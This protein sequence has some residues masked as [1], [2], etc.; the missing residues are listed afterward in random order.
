MTSRR[1]T[2]GIAAPPN[3]SAHGSWQGPCTRQP[4][5]AL[6]FALG[7][8]A[9]VVPIARAQTAPAASGANSEKPAEPPKSESNSAPASTEDT[10][11]SKPA[12]SA[13]TETKSESSGAE[14][15]AVAANEGEV[16]GKIPMAEPPAGEQKP[17]TA[18]RQPTMAGQVPSKDELDEPGYLPGYRRYIGLGQSPYTPPVAA[19]PGGFTPGYG[20]PMPTKAWTFTFAG[21]ANISAQ[22]SG[23][24]RRNPT[25]DQSGFV[26][27]TPPRT[28]EEWSSFT[29]SS[30]VPG[31]WVSLRFIYGTSKVSANV[32]IDT[33]N[34]SEPTSYYQMGSQSYINNAYLSFTPEPFGK[35]RLHTNAGQMVSSYGLLGKY[36]GGVYVNPLA[37]TLRGIGETTTVEYDL[38][39]KITLSAEHGF[40]TTRDATPPINN[41]PEVS[42]GYRRLYWAGAYINHAHLGLKLNG[43]YE[44]TAELHYVNAFSHEDRDQALADN[45]QTP[46]I[47]ESYVKDPH[48]HVYTADVKISHDVWGLLGVGVSY[49]HAKHSYRLKGLLTYGGDGEWLTDRWFGVDDRRLGKV[50][51][52]SDQLWVQSRKNHGL[53]N[54][55]FRQWAR[56]VINTAIH[57]TKTWTDYQPY[58]G[59]VRWKGA[60][61]GLYTFIRYV[62][63]GARIDH[64][65]PNSYDSG[66][67]Y[68]VLATRL[69]FKTDWQSR[70]TVSLIYGKWFYGPRT[71]NEGTGLRTP[72][73]L[74]DNLFALNFNMWW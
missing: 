25:P 35:L 50:V 37:A 11:K 73:R 57:W 3:A 46:E 39:D 48:I 27:H 10:A 67:T 40:M 1:S 70:E 16:I 49:I 24:S 71:R 26:L 19:L 6:C 53:S 20:A 9:A 66:E 43:P 34:P 64:I 22:Y 69:Q 7:S 68:N 28:I 52:W 38:T 51:G 2:R 55:I 54:A 33:W 74:D 45:P 13:T 62:G 47:D 29:S 59:R 36:G 21:S 65:V 58:D 8:L 63:V 17:A 30:T 61:D 15:N 56:L 31:H 60:L 32:S 23:M 5:I 42:N 72:D 4:V 12:D 44:V 41:V 18:A 14:S